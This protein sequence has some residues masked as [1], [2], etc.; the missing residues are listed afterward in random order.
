MQEHPPPVL[1]SHDSAPAPSP[2]LAV[3]CLAIVHR[4]RPQWLAVRI[5]EAA[6]N[7]HLSAERVSRLCSRALPVF[8]SYLTTL[9]R[10]GRPQRSVAPDAEHAT[11]RELAIVRAL[12]A[13]ATTIC[14]HVSLRSRPVR[15]LLLGAWLRLSVEHRSLTQKHFCHTLGIS[16]RTLRSWLVSLPTKSSPAEIAAPTTP[17]PPPRKRRP[18]RRRFSFDLVIPDTQL[19]ADTTDLQTLG[20]ALKLIAAQDIGGRDQNLFDSVIVDDHESAELVISA[21]RDAIDDR[22]GFQV[23]VDQG[24]P[25]MAEITRA[26]LEK[27]GA[28]H[29]PQREGTPTDKSTIERAFGSVKTFARPLLDLS[30][31][32]ADLLPQLRR[33]DL[34]KALTSLVL[35]ALLRAY[36]SGARAA[37]RAENQRAGIDP[38]TL[39]QVAAE[40]REQAR[41]QDHSKRLR[42]QSIYQNYDFDGGQTRFVRSFRRFPL[43][44]IEQAERAFAA[45]AQRTDIS[46]RTAYFAAILRRLNDDFLNRQAELLRHQAHHQQRLRESEQSRAQRQSYLDN[47]VLGLNAALEILPE[48]WDSKTQRLLFDGIGPGRSGARTAIETLTHLHGP[49]SAIDITAATLRDFANSKADLLPAP[50]ITAIVNLVR[51][52]LPPSPKTTPKLACANPFASAI[53]PR[54]GKTLHPPPS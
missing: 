9:T 47:P 46:R 13:V 37:Q 31:R 39:H 10:I 12:L 44:V 21:L 22:E 11:A 50:A 28:E 53:L 26:A 8:E 16:P 51:Q 45:H 6:H 43:P 30:N 7:E 18:Q 52:F 41:V 20:I 49:Q 36:Q 17:P 2:L 4:L 38:S 54:I 5:S 14:E 29:A 24:T 42:L 3:I 48:Y 32:I 34:A 33:P 19:A 25:Y 15:S 40:A 1:F 35:I 23:L 27:L